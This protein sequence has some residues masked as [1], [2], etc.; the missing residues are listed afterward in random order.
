MKIWIDGGIVS[1]QEARVSVLDHGFLYGDGVFE[2]IRAY[3]GRIFR[4]EDHLRRLATGARYLGLEIPGGIDAARAHRP[5]DGARATALP[6]A[7]LRFVVSRGVGELGVDPTTC[8]EP[9]IVC[10]AATIRL[11]APE[12]LAE[13]LSLVDLELAASGASTCSTRA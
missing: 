8:A 12:K 9:R 6:D 2:G 3:G 10:I 7:Y 5:R 1:E 4:L 13:G 11:F